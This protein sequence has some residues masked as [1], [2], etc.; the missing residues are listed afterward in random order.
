M[1]EIVK[2]DVADISCSLQR[3]LDQNRSVSWSV[4][5]KE[6]PIVGSPIFCVFPSDHIT[7]AMKNVNVHFFIH[8]S[9]ACKFYQKQT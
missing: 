8:T 1:T 9:N 3:N 2:N 7:T 6:K 5:L 4:V